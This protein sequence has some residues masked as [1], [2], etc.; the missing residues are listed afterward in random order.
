TSRCSAPPGPGPARAAP[1]ASRD[2]RLARAGRA[3]R[4]RRAQRRPAR[5]GAATPR[6][7]TTG[8]A[9]PRARRSAGGPATPARVSI[10]RSG[11][12]D[13]GRVPGCTPGPPPPRAAG[14]GRGVD[15]TK[16]PG[17]MAQTRVGGSSR[18]R[19]DPARQGGYEPGCR[20]AA[21]AD[22][23]AGMKI[24]LRSG[25]LH[26]SIG[27]SV[28][29]GGRESVRGGSCVRRSG[30]ATSARPVWSRATR[31]DGIEGRVS[32]GAAAGVATRRA[33]PHRAPPG[34]SARPTPPARPTRLRDPPGAARAPRPARASAASGRARCAR[35]GGSARRRRRGGRAA[36]SRSGRG[37]GRGR[38]SRS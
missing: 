28:V 25:D 11:L 23:C 30:V 35:A 13:R 1:S 20:P 12:A 33:P 4:R 22:S 36:G 9:G 29:R 26:R 10:A 21:L 14:S 27:R 8:A 17:A 34:G 15:R 31:S 18:V 3:R 37:R 7:R 24:G 5:R 32:A 38:P 6:G 19:C 16:P 2:G